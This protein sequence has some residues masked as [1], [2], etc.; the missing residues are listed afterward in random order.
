MQI[1]WSVRA[2]DTRSKV[3]HAM[4]WCHCSW[5][6]PHWTKTWIGNLIA[7]SFTWRVLKADDKLE[8]RGYGT[9]FRLCFLC[10]FTALCTFD[11]FIVVFQQHLRIR[12]GSLSSI[13]KGY[14]TNGHFMLRKHDRP[15]R[16]S[17]HSAGTLDRWFTLSRVSALIYK[18]YQWQDQEHSRSTLLL[19]LWSR[20]AHHPSMSF[21]SVLWLV[22]IA[23]LV[24]KNRL[25]T[26]ISLELLL[27]IRD[28]ALGSM[29]LVLSHWNT[30]SCTY[31][32]VVWCLHCKRPVHTDFLRRRLMR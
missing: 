5:C 24:S 20:Y 14:T 30:A 1:A 6:I 26:R 11:H 32:L 22:N 23:P 31:T 15:C 12:Q 2:S 17:P 3:Q 10:P 4:D 21:I 28:S 8:G 7:H 16:H 19:S 9:D 27:C 25:P 18:A 29:R 13:I